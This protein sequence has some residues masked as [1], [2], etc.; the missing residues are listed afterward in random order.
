MII[1][2]N[3]NEQASIENKALE[4]ESSGVSPIVLVPAP[5]PYFPPPPSNDGDNTDL[6]AAQNHQTILSHYRP[7]NSRQPE[8]ASRRFLKAFACA[9]LVIALI[10]M[11]VWSI[12][13]V[14][15]NERR[16]WTNG[17]VT[18]KPGDPKKVMFF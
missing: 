8:S 7:P 1:L 4:A 10:R 13:L 17:L 3:T 6:L 12:D 11:L 16:E 15:S 14:S 9:L 5:P 2:E 18:H